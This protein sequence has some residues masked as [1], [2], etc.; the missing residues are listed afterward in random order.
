MSAAMK[1]QVRGSVLLV[2]GRVLS[3][4]L[5]L[6]TQVLCVRYLSKADYGAFAYAI[7][8][9]E[10]LALLN[11]LGFDNA[12]P[13][14]AAIYDQRKDSRSFVGLLAL[15]FTLVI[16]TGMFVVGAGTFGV[17]YWSAWS[18]ANPSAVNLVLI[19][20]IL[21]PVYAMDAMML[22][23]FGV[24]S[25]ARY[26]MLR[27]H[28]VAPFMRL[29]A[30]L[31][32]MLVEGD[33][34][35]LATAYVI[36]GIGG[37]A[38]FLGALVRVVSK[39]ELMQSWDREVEYHFRENIA[40]NTTIMTSNLVFVFRGTLIVALLEYFHNAPE[41]ADFQAV[42]P[43]G[44]LVELVFANFVVLFIPVISRALASEDK[45][46]IANTHIT[47]QVWI[48]LL[49]FPLFAFSFGFAD[50]LTP[51]L[52]GSEYMSAS[53]VLAWLSLGFY[54]RILFGLSTRTLKVIGQ[55]KAVIFVD[56]TTVCFALG[57]SFWL[58][59]DHAAVGAAISAFLTM[60]FHSLCSQAALFWLNK[61]GLW[62]SK[63]RGLYIN[64]FLCVIT[65]VILRWSFDIR[66]WSLGSIASLMA[67]QLLVMHRRQFDL[68]SNFPELDAK[69]RKI[70]SKLRR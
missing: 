7:A 31:A 19:L 63:T 62:D 18:K 56:V 69:L 2:S 26:V 49:S 20:L 46:A 25:G 3:L 1:D 48:S 35:F 10:M 36:T 32:M 67:A 23:L 44:T 68:I 28:I 43:I 9:I 6:V 11:T 66:D 14:F 40:Y 29:F 53:E 55:L 13:R 16:I 15:S 59:P 60:T 12:L 30:V 54:L 33:N 17:E 4:V 22:G 34:I 37:V 70:R 51:L 24:F 21:A 41:V 58:I 39:T 47:T 38:V 5:N 52:F 27:K 45:Q 64:V 65:L 42:K 57:V 8:L 50:I 61:I